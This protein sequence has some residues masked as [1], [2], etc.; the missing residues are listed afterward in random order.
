MSE[1]SS[2]SVS[3]SLLV[4]AWSL[5]ELGHQAVRALQEHN[6]PTVGFTQDTQADNAGGSE[7]AFPQSA[8]TSFC[9]LDSVTFPL[10]IRQNR[11]LVSASRDVLYSIQNYSK[12]A[13]TQ[14]RA[15]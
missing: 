7:E 9:H 2:V 13:V 14:R 8:W 6:G 3:C 15:R 11:E 4:Q 12:N 10:G 5:A 1:H